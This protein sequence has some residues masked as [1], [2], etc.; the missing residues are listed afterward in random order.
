MKIGPRISDATAAWLEGNFQSRNAGAQYVLGAFPELCRV[1]L[2]ELKGRFSPGELSLMIDALQ[3]T[4]PTPQLAGQHLEASIVD[5]IELDKLD[6]KWSVRR[7]SIMGKI[8]DL[9]LLERCCL[10][11]W[12]CS[13]SPEDIPKEFVYRL[14]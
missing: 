11:I 5:A 7:A 10:E 13:F 6:G 3:G 14:A 1:T 8:M 9:T 2:R 4:L 12:C